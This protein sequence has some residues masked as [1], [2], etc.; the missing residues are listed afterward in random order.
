M[1]HEITMWHT[2]CDQVLQE[3]PV[4]SMSQ[5]Q[6]ETYFYSLVKS[7]GHALVRAVKRPRTHP[8]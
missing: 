2:R 4:D 7:Q 6:I 5:Y 3:S 1:L 8:A